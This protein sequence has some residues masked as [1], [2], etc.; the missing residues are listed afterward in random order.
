MA[1]TT[2]AT[3][4]LL[5][6]P[7]LGS[8][9][10][11]TPVPSSARRTRLPPAA[12]L[13][14]RP[15]AM[16]RPL[17]QR[18]QARGT[19]GGS[20]SATAS[21]GSVCA[22]GGSAAATADVGAGGVGVGGG[23]ARETCRPQAPAVVLPTPALRAGGTEASLAPSVTLH[24]TKF[25]TMDVFGLSCH[26]ISVTRRLCQPPVQKSHLDSPWTSRPLTNFGQ[27]CH[28]R[29]HDNQALVVKAPPPEKPTRF[30][31]SVWEMCG[32]QPS[33]VW[34]ECGLECG[35]VKR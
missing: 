33:G 22:G 10:A 1:P 16:R 13:P 34:R 26:D 27:L 31:Q 19:T 35:N 29:R 17:P 12:R 6:Q 3:L 24:P 11:Q 2:R 14:R 4:L 18:A 30:P 28:G 15:T 23:R 21:E 9:L 32:R 7:L 5:R 8:P 20:A 25:Q